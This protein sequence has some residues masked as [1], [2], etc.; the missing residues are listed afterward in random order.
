M[1]RKKIQAGGMRRIMKT[2]Y[3]PGSNEGIQSLRDQL[4]VASHKS[5]DLLAGQQRARMPV[6][7]NQQIEIAAVPDYRSTSEQPL[8]LFWIVAFVGRC[9][10]NSLRS[11]FVNEENRPIGIIAG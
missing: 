3:K 11:R 4:H 7:E 5:G 6:Q 2:L 1:D 8:D 9:R 10:D